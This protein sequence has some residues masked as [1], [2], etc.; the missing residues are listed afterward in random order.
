MATT[1]TKLAEQIVRI[2]DGGNVSDDSRIS[3]REVMALIDRERHSR[4]KLIEDRFYTKAQQLT[5]LS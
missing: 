4:K 2:L 5:K 1:R 3:K